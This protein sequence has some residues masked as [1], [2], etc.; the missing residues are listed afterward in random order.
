MCGRFSA[1]SETDVLKKRFK[2]KGL[3]IK[4]RKN[5]NNR[6]KKKYNIAPLDYAQVITPDLVINEF[7]WGLVPPFSKDSCFAPK[8]I[9]ARAETVNQKLSFKTLFEKGQRCL[10]P[11]E[12]FYEFPISE[13]G[14]HAYRICLKDNQIFSFAG[15]YSSWI[16][17]KTQENL[18]TF[19]ILTCPPNSLIQPEVGLNI[20]DRMPVLLAEKNEGLWLSTDTSHEKLLNILKPYPSDTMKAYEV[21]ESVKNVHF[22]G[23]DCW[24][25]FEAVN[26]FDWLK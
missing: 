2:A 16:N 7:R 13:G 9:N 20:H 22:E 6:V 15:L 11:S 17:P 1:I 24:K 3:E 19:T 10:I 25:A 4:K 18:N 12:G 23:E 26:P 8:M 21:N 14:K 5:I